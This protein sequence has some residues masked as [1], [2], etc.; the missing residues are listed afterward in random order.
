MI[1]QLIREKR[2][3]KELT[4]SDVAKKLGYGNSQFVALMEQGKSK[5]PFIV[6]GKLFVILSFTKKEQELVTNHFI[7]KYSATVHSGIISGKLE[8][9]RG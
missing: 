8:A 5:V 6:L 7:K 2:E 3:A 9:E 1:S 4:Q